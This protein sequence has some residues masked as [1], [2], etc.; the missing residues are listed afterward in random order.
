MSPT[1]SCTD[2]E[3]LLAIADPVLA[4]DY[5]HQTVLYFH[6]LCFTKYTSPTQPQSHPEWLTLHERMQL[7]TA[8][9]AVMEA[10]KNQIVVNDS[11]KNIIAEAKGSGHVEPEFPP[12]KD[13]VSRLISGPATVCDRD[14]HILYLHLPRVLTPD[15]LAAVEEACR[16]LVNAPYS[17]M[18]MSSDKPG[19]RTDPKFF[20]GGGTSFCAFTPGVLNLSP[21]WFMQNHP[22]PKHQ[23]MVSASI[24]RRDGKDGAIPFLRDMR[25][26]FTV[27]GAILYVLNPAQYEQG[28]DAW[29]KMVETNC[30]GA[31]PK[32]AD[33]MARVLRIWA[34]P[35]TVTQVIS[36]R[37]TPFHYD[38]SGDVNWA[39]GSN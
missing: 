32:Y 30:E 23:P 28:V 8:S 20:K 10:L 36:N 19:W 39:G 38:N 11:L 17:K 29:K 3:D 9:D 25:M 4:L 24:R 6:Q 22:P 18:E 31:A 1:T 37:Q 2:D 34:S 15:Q 27:M 21:C 16:S 12:K 35:F 14:G 7:Y 13:G 26:S 33:L 5:L